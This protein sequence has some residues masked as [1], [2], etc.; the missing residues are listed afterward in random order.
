V[1]IIKAFRCGSTCGRHSQDLSVAPSSPSQN[2]EP[3][4]TM[5][6][7]SSYRKRKHTQLQP[8]RVLACDEALR[9]ISQ[10]D[11]VPNEKTAVPLEKTMARGTHLAGE[12]LKLCSKVADAV[13]MW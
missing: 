1:P 4:V 7:T 6:D 9:N 8:L 13:S 12:K 10:Q 2:L 11:L 5:C 3:A